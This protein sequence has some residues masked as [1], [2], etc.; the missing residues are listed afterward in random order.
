MSRRLTQTAHATRQRATHHAPT[1]RHM[2]RHTQRTEHAA[3][4]RADLTRQ[5]DAATMS[6]CIMRVTSK[7]P[8]GATRP[9]SR[10]NREL[11]AGSRA[12]QVRCIRVVCIACS[13]PC[14]RGVTNKERITQGTMHTAKRNDR[15][16]YRGTRYCLSRK[17]FRKITGCVFKKCNGGLKGK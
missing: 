10:S 14:R 12:L 9:H 2:T 1:T 16:Y 7:P 5:A 17:I 13:E 15:G 11:A 4:R 3:R 6:R 8:L